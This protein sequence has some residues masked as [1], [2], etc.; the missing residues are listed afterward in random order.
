MLAGQCAVDVAIVG[1]GITGAV[2]AQKL[3]AA[4]VRVALIEGARVGKGSTAASSALLLQEPDQGLA[5]LAARHG[6][7]AGRRVWELSHQAVADLVATLSRLRISCDVAS[8]DTVYVATSGE[9]VRQLQRDLRHRTEAGFDGTWLTAAALRRTT[10]IAAPGAILTRG[11]AQLNPYRACVGLVRAAAADGAH[12][13]ERSLVQRVEQRANGIR[14]RTAHGTVDAA[15]VVIATGYATKS[16]RPLAGRFRMYRTYVATTARLTAAA[17][18]RIGLGDVMMWDA[19][20]PYHYARWTADHRLLI[21]GGDRPAHGGRSRSAR[22]REAGNGL[23]HAFA[24]LLPRVESLDFELIWEGLFALTRDSLPF[25]GPH[26]RYPRH[27]FALGYGGNG[28]TFASLAARILLEHWQGVRSADH[29]L[30]AFG[31]FR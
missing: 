23:R 15:R 7:A 13:F 17:R 6:R 29:A 11:N 22:L 20:R 10:G 2:T 31:R 30:F 5:E 27:L 4:G 25:I 26:R 14:L 3:A 1:G 8:R 28:M 24:R 12:V 19:N 9:H 16:F 18:R 21:G